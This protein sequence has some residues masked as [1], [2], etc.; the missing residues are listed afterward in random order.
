[1][2]LSEK[3]TLVLLTF[4]FVLSAFSLASITR[5]ALD[6]DNAKNWWIVSFVDPRGDTLDFTIANH[7]DTTRYSYTT[8]APDHSR[9]DEA[10]S[11][12]IPTGETR[13]LSPIQ[14]KTTTGKYSITIQHGNETRTLYK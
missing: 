11:V 2:H 14:K 4:I 8:T 3:N 7:S 13:T 10:I 12:D 6:P 9:S 5:D 1:M